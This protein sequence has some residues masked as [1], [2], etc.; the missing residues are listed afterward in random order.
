VSVKRFLITLVLALV[1]SATAATAA[2]ARP[3]D[4]VGVGSTV[5]AAPSTTSYTPEGSDSSSSPGFDWGDAGIGAAAAFAVTMVGLGGVL[6]VSARR[7]HGFQ[8]RAA[9]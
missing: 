7:R 3:I 4:A 2:S 1:I 5:S 8:G 6:V 9:A